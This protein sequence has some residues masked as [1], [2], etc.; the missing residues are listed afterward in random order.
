MTTGND[1]MPTPDNGTI[2]VVV[3]MSGGVDSSVAALL[4]LRRGYQVEGLFMQNWE[5]E[6][7]DQCTAIQDYRDAAGVCQLLGIPLHT[8]NFSNSYQDHVFSHF[9]EEYQ[10][11]NTPN[12]DVMC[13]KEIKFKAFLNHARELGAD[14]IA[15]GH[16]ARCSRQDKKIQLLRG[17]DTGKDQTYFLYTLGQAQLRQVLF[18]IGDLSKKQVRALA[19]QARFHNHAKRDSTGICFIGERKFND[20]LANYL[21]AQ[22]GDIM[23]DRGE[24]L[25]RHS[26]LMFYTLGQRQGLGIGGRRETSGE[27]W[28]V[29]EKCLNTK[30]LIVVQGHNHPLLFKSQLRAAQLHWCTGESPAAIFN[31]TAKVR[32]RQCDQACAVTLS[33]CQTYAAVNFAEPVRAITPGQSIVFY[34]KDR[35][36]GGGIIQGA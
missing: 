23:S 1:K 29:V 25:G 22:P 9:L 17:V 16:Y 15:T 14:Y 26:G 34:R 35:C 36:L 27:P 11:G 30:R 24:L 28:Y 20:F 4:L 10:A 3:G 19:K 13:N 6:D 31:C 32:Y 8:V 33:T 12:P 21:P 18:P 7:E 2:R 5:E